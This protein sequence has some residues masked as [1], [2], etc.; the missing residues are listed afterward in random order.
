MK[1]VVLIV[2][3]CVVSGCG[4]KIGPEKDPWLTFPEGFQFQVD[5]NNVDHV[6]DRKGLNIEKMDNRKIEKY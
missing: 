1:K 5:V 3:L 6:L 2:I 4:M